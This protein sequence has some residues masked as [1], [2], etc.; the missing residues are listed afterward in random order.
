MKQFD[1]KI[2]LIAFI[3]ALLCATTS[4]TWT[5]QNKPETKNIEPTN[6]TCFLKQLTKNSF[7]GIGVACTIYLLQKFEI[8]SSNTKL[9]PLYAGIA[10]TGGKYLYDYLNRPYTTK[11]LLNLIIKN[12]KKGRMYI[13]N[14]SDQFEREI[15]L[16][17]KNKN[18]SG[19]KIGTIIKK[20]E[21]K[22]PLLLLGECTLNDDKPCIFSRDLNP[23]VRK[24]FE[25]KVVP[26][27]LEKLKTSKEAVHYVSFGA[28]GM[29]QDL[30]ILTKTL[31]KNPEANIII[32]FIDP[33]FYLE[34]LFLEYLHNSREV[35]KD[36]NYAPTPQAL[37][38]FLEL[39]KKDIGIQNNTY[40]DETIKKNLYV[41][42]SV[43]GKALQE[44]ISFLQNNFPKAKLSLFIH[45]E[46][47]DYLPYV[48]N[49]KLPYPD[50]IAAADIQD[51][52][53]LFQGSLYHYTK[54]CLI[55][56]QNKPSSI[57]FLLGKETEKQANISTI[58]RTEIKGAQKIDFG[59][60][61]LDHN[62][63]LKQYWKVQQPL[64]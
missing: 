20:Y 48:E 14:F 53:S 34:V 55:S 17:R 6:S 47:D 64:N 7:L 56:Q 12:P 46:T 37:N 57:N 27:L 50:V 9:L 30:V 1:T 25:K 2:I 35:K 63:K 13:E 51:M 54:L 11:E 3:T 21:E 32:H 15:I 52:M 8:I 61:R 62:K 31:N 44:F 10:T 39:G 33:K 45:S 24:L 60:K 26:A 4:P 38:H 28:G 5:I 22:C 42:F 59:E 29:F 43:L 18:D 36:E 16:I 40:D 23:K 19:R 41:N 58:S 49:H